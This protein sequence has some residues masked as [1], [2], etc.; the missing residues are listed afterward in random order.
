MDATKL[1]STSRIVAWKLLWSAAY[2]PLFLLAVVTSSFGA[3]HERSQPPRRRLFGQLLAWADARAVGIAGGSRW[4]GGRYF[5]LVATDGRPPSL[6]GR[7][8]T[9]LAPVRVAASAR[10]RRWTV[11]EI[12]LPGA[13]HAHYVVRTELLPESLR[14]APTTGSG[15]FR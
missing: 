7:D 9:V 15:T 6:I 12:E 5:Q 11:M 3:M 1:P 4:F 13:Q 14:V 2:V 8:G 10:R